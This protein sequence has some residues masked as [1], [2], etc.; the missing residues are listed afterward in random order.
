ML[1]AHC[2]RYAIDSLIVVP[3]K[4]CHAIRYT[5]SIHTLKMCDNSFAVYSDQLCTLNGNVWFAVVKRCS[6][7][8]DTPFVVD[9][10]VARTVCATLSHTWL[11]LILF[12]A[13][14]SIHDTFIQPC[15]W[16]HTAQTLELWNVL[17]VS[18]EEITKFNLKFEWIYVKT[19]C[20]PFYYLFQWTIEKPVFIAPEKYF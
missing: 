17:C 12:V 14:K 13:D 19:V 18:A 1:H 11:E 10:G 5:N 15:H 4:S 2:F 7:N 6:F 3:W 9:F 8:A 16:S 20:L